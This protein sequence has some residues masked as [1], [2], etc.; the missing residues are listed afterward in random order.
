MTDCPFCT[1]PCYNDHCSYKISWVSWPGVVFVEK[2]VCFNNFKN[3]SLICLNT[4]EK[5]GEGE[6]LIDN[7]QVYLLTIL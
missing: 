3:V 6:T 7:E 2:K 1:T 4:G 5:T